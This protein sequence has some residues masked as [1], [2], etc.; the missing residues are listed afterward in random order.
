MVKNKKC[1]DNY[2]NALL[3]GKP[4]DDQGKLLDQV[5]LFSMQYLGMKMSGFFK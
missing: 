1:M 4:T 5:I 2:L 3:E